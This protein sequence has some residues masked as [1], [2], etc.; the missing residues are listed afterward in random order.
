MYVDSSRP[1]PISM[2]TGISHVNWQ[3]I[4]LMRAVP[5]TNTSFC[6][7]PSIT[8]TRQGNPIAPFVISCATSA[9]NAAT[10]PSSAGG[11]STNAPSVQ[12]EFQY[13]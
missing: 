9:S 1:T 13:L 7:I 10:N 6:G 8:Y 5:C 2:A 11:A 3:S 12:N 4:Y